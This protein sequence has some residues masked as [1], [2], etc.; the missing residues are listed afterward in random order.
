MKN[1][2]VI[3]KT[4][5][6]LKAWAVSQENI[7]YSLAKVKS[8]LRAGFQELG[9][10]M[11]HF[12]PSLQPALISGAAGNTSYPIFWTA[13]LFIL[14]RRYGRAIREYFH[15]RNRLM[16]RIEREVILPREVLRAFEKY[17]T[18]T[19]EEQNE[20]EIFD[21][22]GGVKT[23]QPSSVSDSCVLVATDSVKGSSTQGEKSNPESF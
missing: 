9:L 10:V 12:N 21:V 16:E 15:K 17:G 2:Q 13:T 5:N 20:L 4:A 1:R 7:S 22:L 14:D 18:Y 11:E 8:L 23:T 3:P 6:V 19:A